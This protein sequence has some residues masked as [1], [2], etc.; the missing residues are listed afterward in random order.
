M[1][2]ALRC[3]CRTKVG[4]PEVHLAAAGD[5]RGHGHRGRRHCASRA[6]RTTKM[7]EAVGAQVDVGDGCWQPDISRDGHHKT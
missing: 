3:V 5:G 7:S 1:Y 4:S 6:L 2:S